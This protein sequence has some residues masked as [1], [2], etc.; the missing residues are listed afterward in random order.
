M[1][2]V[3]SGV[4]QNITSKILPHLA[5]GGVTFS[6]GVIF[7]SNTK[8]HWFYFSLFDCLVGQLLH[9]K[10]LPPMIFLPRRPPAR[11]HGKIMYSLMRGWFILF[12]L[13]T[14]L[15]HKIVSCNK[16]SVSQFLDHLYFDGVVR[17]V[18]VL[19]PF[20]VQFQD[21]SINWKEILRS[22]HCKPS[23]SRWML[24]FFTISRVIDNTQVHWRTIAQ[25][26]FSSYSKL[27][28]LEIRPLRT[29]PPI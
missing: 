12:L 15:T 24:E 2:T 11:L 4:G 6:L 8:Q 17:Q 14:R 18:K 23:S 16:H 19:Y 10:P 26:V 7:L 22:L 21:T 28:F 5:L 29:T 25:V 3:L 20:F 9:T 27:L 1:G 13:A